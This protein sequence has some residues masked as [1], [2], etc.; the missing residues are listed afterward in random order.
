ML[1]RVGNRTTTHD[2]DAIFDLEK[3]AIYNAARRVAEQEGLPDDW[4][5]EAAKIA[6]RSN[7]PAT[8]WK[9]YPGLDVYMPKNG[10][11]FLLVI[12]YLFVFKRNP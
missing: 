4:I 11:R 8:L 5:N 2:I 12:I 1:I 3:S 7:P 10:V 9:Q 6:I